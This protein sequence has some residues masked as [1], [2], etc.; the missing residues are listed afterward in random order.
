MVPEGQSSV[1]GDL[2][3]SHERNL[4]SSKLISS[5]GPAID[6][7]RRDHNGGKSRA[8]IP[9]LLEWIGASACRTSQTRR[10]GANGI[11]TPTTK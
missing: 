5:V 2:R 7:L 4:V 8:A 1:V 10:R 3:N 6:H 11:W 9:V